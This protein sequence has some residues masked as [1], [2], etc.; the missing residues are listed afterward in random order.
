MLIPYNTASGN[1]MTVI[2]TETAKEY[3]AD[4]DADNLVIKTFSLGDKDVNYNL[5]CNRS[6]RAICTSQQP[7]HV[8]MRGVL[9]DSAQLI[10]VDEIKN[11]IQI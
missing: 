1:V 10:N 8:K 9:G 4:G 11:K 3:L 7:T 5:I 6:A 2:L